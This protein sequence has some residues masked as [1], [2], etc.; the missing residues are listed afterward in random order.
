MLRAPDPYDPELT[1]PFDHGAFY[2]DTVGSACLVRSD[3]GPDRLRCWCGR[4]IVSD[5]DAD[6]GWSH[7]GVGSR[8]DPEGQ[9]DWE[10]N[11]RTA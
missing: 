1:S 4:E 2:T 5:E 6:T 10:R 3:S 8:S 11:V 9:L 7:V